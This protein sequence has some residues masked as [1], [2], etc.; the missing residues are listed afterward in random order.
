ML[1]ET[2]M[3]NSTRLF[4][5]IMLG[6]FWAGSASAQG[7]AL[8]DSGQDLPPDISLPLPG[9]EGIRRTATPPPSDAA[10]PQAPSQS[11]MPGADSYGDYP[12]ADDCENYH[13]DV[14]GLLGTMA[15]IESTGTWLRRGF[16]Y[17][18][19][20]AVVMNRLWNRDDKLMA[21]ED[22]QVDDPAF[23]ERVNN[24][25][26]LLVTNFD[27]NRLLYLNGA[28]PGQDA[29]VR[30]T[31]GH[32]L[33]RDAHNRDHTMEFTAFGSG[34]WEQ[35][36]VISS[37]AP[38]GLMVPFYIDGTDRF[39][40]LEP[41][42][43][44]PEGPNFDFSSRQRIIYDSQF[45]SFEWNYRVRGRLGHDQLVMD[46]NGCWHRAADPG[47]EREYLIGLRFLNLFDKF[48]WTAEDIAA[49]GGNPAGDGRYLI[50]T[51]NDLFGFQMGT[52]LSYQAARWS[53]G[54][55]IKGGVFVNDALGQTQLDFTA[56]DA[57]DADLRL[58]EKALSF[59][60][61][62]RLQGRYHILP[63]CSLRAGYEMMYI[64]SVALAP[65]QATFITDFSY[66]N[67]TG[68]PFYHGASFGFEG[69]W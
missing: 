53:L 51:D 15:P 19:A 35:D 1:G 66:L 40:Q 12:S 56:D 11:S 37:T 69:F 46:A 64:T 14:P 22:I 52:G 29:S 13:P 49:N 42:A 55:N 63:N 57:R 41:P 36:R 33:F 21:A 16:W 39:G 65:Y 58:Q 28:N 27:T 5:L 32:F 18:E 23:L 44:P 3:T 61:E 54:T 45:K 26:F 43:R 17:A 62:F 25:S 67:T 48:D 38:N 47:F 31:L 6:V 60:G 4:G 59:V 7:L 50:H 2:N 9:S 8:P 20:D 30:G 24:P 34:D 68:D 10:A